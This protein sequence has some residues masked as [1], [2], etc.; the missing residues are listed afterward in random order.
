MC[1]AYLKVILYIA[2]S[3]SRYKSIRHSILRTAGL[4]VSCIEENRI[5]VLECGWIVQKVV[6]LRS[7]EFSGSGKSKAGNRTNLEPCAKFL[8]IRRLLPNL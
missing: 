1:L 7:G 3:V 2:K 8:S 6:G 5:G 4:L